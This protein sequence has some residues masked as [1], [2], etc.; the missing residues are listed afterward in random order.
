MSDRTPDF[1]AVVIGGGFGG[2]Y[3]V[4]KL[5]PVPRGTLRHRLDPLPVL[6][7]RT[8]AAIRTGSRSPGRA[9]ALL[10]PPIDPE[11]RTASKEEFAGPF[12][13]VAALDGMWAGYLGGAEV[14]ALCAPNRAASLSRLAPA[15]VL[16]CECD[17]TRDEAEA[18]GHAL[19]AAGVPAEVQRLSGFMHA[20]LNLN[21]L[22]PRVEEIYDAIG[23][24]AAEHL[25]NAPRSR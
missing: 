20:A 3:A 16:T 25:G 18:Y 1:D 4:H 2:I 23:K 5:R 17:P 14:T 19:A 6:L 21:A 7:R 24:F 11:A 8:S 22:V 12:L 15:L 13:T 9:P 10:Y